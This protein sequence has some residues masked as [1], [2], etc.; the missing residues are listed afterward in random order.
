MIKSRCELNKYFI[1]I[2]IS[3]LFLISACS[4]KRSDPSLERALDFAGSNKSELEKVL[5]HYSKD[6]A[7]SLKLKAAKFLIINMPYH[8]GYYGEEINRYSNIFSIIDTFSYTHE[9][10]SNEDRAHIGDS[11][12]GIYGE[13]NL[14]NIKKE[15]D[16]KIITADYLIK[17]IDFAFTAL[18]QTA[19]GRK[20]PF[21]DFCE[22][23]LPYRIRNEQI[24]DW[25][26]EYYQRYMKMLHSAPKP[27]D[28]GDTYGYMKWQLGGETNFDVSFDKYFPF[29]Q[30]VGDIEKG[31]IGSCE[32]TA[33]AAVTAMRSVGLPVGYDYIM[34]WG[35]ANS[36][37]YMPALTD[38]FDAIHLITNENVQ[39]D[40]W[41]L[42]DFSSE[43]NANRHKFLQSEMPKGLYVQNVKTIPKVYRFTYS[44]SQALLSINKNVPKEYI[45]P[46][47]QQTNLKDVTDEYVTTANVKIPTGKEVEKYKVGYLTVFDISGWQP[48]AVA[49]MKNDQIV[50]NKLGKETVYLPT[51]Y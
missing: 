1:L 2:I 10:I 17:N 6:P 11:I 23:I 7:D 22:Y 37:H 24:D 25:R 47:F 39:E 21:D 9:N 31:R 45:S 19:W 51:V 3:G 27:D 38:R 50:F 33:F 44:Q 28:L 42:V 41:H 26:P 15:Y 30:S 35:T 14:D 36:R 48:V 34:H 12:I 8:Y 49:E 43:Y 13:P 29:D 4:C 46:E 20:I 18:R 32:I 16:S 40:T 5:A